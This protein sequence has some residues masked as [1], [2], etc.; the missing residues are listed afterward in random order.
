LERHETAAYWRR[1]AE[2]CRGLAS[3]VRSADIR[4]TLVELA[5]EFERKA[6]TGEPAPAG[7]RPAAGIVRRDC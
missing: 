2:F 1:K 6:E 3:R 5:S 4:M 7:A